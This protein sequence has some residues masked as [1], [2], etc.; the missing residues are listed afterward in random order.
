VVLHGL[1]VLLEYTLILH[2]GL[3]AG[4]VLLKQFLERLLV[5]GRDLSHHDLVVCLTAVLE[6]HLVYLPDRSDCLVAFLRL[7]ED[8]LEHLEEAN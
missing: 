8:R 2:I 5:L 1:D 4:E 6:Q 3:D 7:C